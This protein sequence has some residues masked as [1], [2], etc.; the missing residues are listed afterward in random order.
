LIDHLGLIEKKLDQLVT[1][2]P[3][4]PHH[5]LFEAARYTLLSSGKRLRPLL[6]LATVEAYQIPLEKALAPACA[7]EMIHTYSLIHDDLPCMDDDD[8]RRG[9]PTLHKVYPEGHAVLTGDF[10]LTYAFQILSEAPHLTPEQRLQL[11]QS[12]SKSSGADGLI[13]GQVVD[14]SSA[15]HKTDWALLQFMHLGKTAA[16]IRTALEFGGI[17]ADAPPEDLQH[18]TTA[19]T[20][21]GLAFQLV[22]DILDADQ[23]QTKATAVSILGLNEANKHIEL[24]F[25]SATQ[26]LQSLSRPAPARAHNAH[27]L[28]HR[29][30]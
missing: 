18:L 9:K 22:D 6:T 12:L 30:Q 21:L 8:L 20:H 10:L 29:T 3:D 19:G 2:R 13:G 11:I 4:V 5:L 26:A 23:E 1:S 17:L 27:Q 15:P 24:L 7:L 14:L 25:T 16:L 28:V